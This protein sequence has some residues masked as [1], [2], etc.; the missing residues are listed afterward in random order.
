MAI[1][2]ALLAR[3]IAPGLGRSF[4]FQQWKTIDMAMFDEIK[5]EATKKQFTTKTYQIYGSDSDEKMLA[6]ATANAE[7]AGVADTITFSQYDI[8]SP[9]LPYDLEKLTI[10]SNPPYGKRLTG[11]DLGQIY[12]HLI[13]HIQNSIGG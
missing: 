10:V 8:L 5:N 4:A 2:A 7:K 3:N 6:I 9:L 13:S 12:T 11:I 1:E